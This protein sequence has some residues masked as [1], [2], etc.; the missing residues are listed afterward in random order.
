[1]VAQAGVSI[2]ETSHTEPLSFML[3]LT[4]YNRWQIV[5]PFLFWTMQHFDVFP[6][7]YYPLDQIFAKKNTMLSSLDSELLSSVR[8][9]LKSWRVKLD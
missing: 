8:S 2:L 4:V 9:W 3:K 5:C 1:M 7:I 6:F